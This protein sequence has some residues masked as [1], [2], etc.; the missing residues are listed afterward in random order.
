MNTWIN[1]TFGKI[2]AVM[3]FF[4]CA[5]DEHSGLRTQIITTEVT[6]EAIKVTDFN[7]ARNP[8]VLV[9]HKTHHE[10]INKLMGMT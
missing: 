2:R 3:C 8:G 1:P 4:S 6:C 5:A 9:C 7:S 10:P